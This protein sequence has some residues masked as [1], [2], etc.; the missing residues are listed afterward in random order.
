MTELPIGTIIG[1]RYRVARVL[2]S[3]GF[4]TVYEAQHLHMTRA[5]AVKVLNIPND[6][7]NHREVCRRFI[8]E[9]EAASRID[10]NNVVT[11]YDVGFTGSGRQPFIAMKLLR[12][13]DLEE[14]LERSGAM[15]PT[16]A[17]PLFLE[18]LDALA[19]AHEAGIIHKDLKPGN[20]FLSE[21]G[22]DRERLHIVD[23]G[24]AC[25]LEVDNSRITATGQFLGTP[26]YVAPEYVRTQTASPALDVY[27]MALILIEMICGAA[28][29]EADHVYACIMMHCTG[30]LNIP[31]PLMKGPLQDVLIK[32]LAFDHTR[33]YPDAGSFRDALSAIDP[34]TIDPVGPETPRRSLAAIVGQR[35][36]L[37]NDLLA[38][39]RELDAETPSETPSVRSTPSAQRTGADQVLVDEL[40]DAVGGTFGQRGAAGQINGVDLT[41]GV[42]DDD[43]QPTGFD[44]SAARSAKPVHASPR[45]PAA[46]SNRATPSAP[47]PGGEAAAAAR[48]APAPV[49]NLDQTQELHRDLMRHQR[50]TQ[51]VIAALIAIAVIFGGAW[52][53]SLIES[54]QGDA[55]TLDAAEGAEQDPAERPTLAPDP[56]AEVKPTT[57]G[58]EAS[59]PLVPKEIEAPAVEQVN[60][61]APEDGPE[62][63]GEKVAEAVD[64]ARTTRLTPKGQGDKTQGRVAD[65]A[66][67][68]KTPPEDK[69][70]APD[71]AEAKTKGLKLAP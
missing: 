58:N 33:R 50:R 39:Q 43:A 56:D 30:E 27:Q 2:G 38:L 55:S 62:S 44:A 13:H 32:A 15:A 42:S 3:G 61:P 63:P 36:E 34:Q 35:R 9:A 68:D 23:F 5:V 40:R 4:G 37:S 8:Q 65:T 24:M 46:A 66:P 10:H 45:T 60:P 11:I 54:A 67:K 22:T 25:I 6:K 31:I 1:E 69:A 18:C 47:S 70:P 57:A 14:E 7:P 12:G 59:A 28:V 41:D 71:P 51:A 21:P 48:V 29:V 20:L 26:K 19:V 64:K 53:W 52:I 16:R 49:D 17:L